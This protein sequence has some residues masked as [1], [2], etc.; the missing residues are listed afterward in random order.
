MNKYFVPFKAIAL[1]LLVFIT[2]ICAFAQLPKDVYKIEYKVSSNIPNE[3]V[4]LINTTS[5]TKTKVMLPEPSYINETPRFESDYIIKIPAIKFSS[6]FLKT[7]RQPF[8]LYAVTAEGGFFLVDSKY[9]EHQFTWVNKYDCFITANG[10]IFNEKGDYYEE[11]YSI[12]KYDKCIAISKKVH[13]IASIDY[14]KGCKK[15]S[16]TTPILDLVDFGDTVLYLLNDSIVYYSISEDKQLSK[17]PSIY[18]SEINKFHKISILPTRI[19][20]ASKRIPIRTEQGKW[21][22][23]NEK[24]ETTIQPF[25]ADLALPFLLQKEQ[26]PVFLN[27]KWGIMNTKGEMTTPFRFDSL[28][29][30]KNISEI[31]LMDNKEI[32]HINQQTGKIE[33]KYTKPL[34]TQTTKPDEVPKRNYGSSCLVYILENN[35]SSY[36][37]RAHILVSLSYDNDNIEHSHMSSWTRNA[38]HPEI[39]GLW[40]KGYYRI[41]EQWSNPYNAD[42]I[43]DRSCYHYRSEYEQKSDLLSVIEKGFY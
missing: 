16:L 19:Y 34:E 13:N 38:I 12:L 39:S 9:N 41:S 8:Y 10:S 37:K 3:F 2:H 29:I 14:F 36:T 32:F 4:W 15:L 5:K 7:D 33:P 35:N 11:Y 1:S 6:D 30:G 23:M 17:L 25:A 21:A 18:S 26:A 43:L 31:E 22:Y 27:G 42:I 20:K 40:E 28:K 24:M